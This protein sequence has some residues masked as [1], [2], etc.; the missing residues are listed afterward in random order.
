MGAG[1]SMPGLYS[2]I[3]ILLCLVVLWMGNS[4]ERKQ[5]DKAGK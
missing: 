3:A 4:S 1:G 2:V 5:Y